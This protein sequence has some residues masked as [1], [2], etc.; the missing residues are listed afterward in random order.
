MLIET[1]VTKTQQVEIPVPSFYRTKDEK[2]YIGIL[3]DTTIVSLY[4][5]D[6]LK[7]VKNCTP[8]Y[9][10]AIK[11]AYEKWHSC[12]ETEFLE[13]YDAVIESISLH[14]KLAV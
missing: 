7:I 11:E 14:P 8:M 10:G 1:T 3:D 4:V 5:S 9:E 2:N 12:T 13:K 6:E